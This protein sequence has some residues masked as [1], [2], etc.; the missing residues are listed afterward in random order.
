[1]IHQTDLTINLL[2][3]STLNPNI[4]AWEY[5]QGHFDYKATPLVPL[6][7]PLMINHKASNCKSWDYIGREVWSVGVALDHYQ[8]QW[9]IPHNTK[10]DKISDTVE[11]RHQTTTTPMV[12]PKDRILHGLKT[13]TD[14]L[15]DLPKSQS[16]A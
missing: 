16:D 7:C 12:N 11:L 5:F 4:S 6:G 2:R 8:C 3:Q 1:M 13:I 15:M 9:I 10:V 14:D